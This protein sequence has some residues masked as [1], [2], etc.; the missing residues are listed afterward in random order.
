MPTGLSTRPMQA[1]G[2]LIARGDGA[3]PEVFVTIPGC[4]G[5][6]VPQP[7]LD[8]V[9]VTSHDTTGG[10]D[11]VIPSIKHGQTVDITMNMIQGNATQALLFA[12]F[13][14]RAVSNYKV[15]LPVP[16]GG[17]TGAV[18]AFA[19]YVT[20]MTPTTDV[21]KQLTWKSIL[22]VAGAV[23]FTDAV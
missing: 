8:I 14:A 10:W 2:T 22:T 11:D 7:K 12:D 4:T 21:T 19:A 1:I 16:S 20:E 9:D 6:P 15:T 17:T 18:F 3:S 23:T 13:E 5:S